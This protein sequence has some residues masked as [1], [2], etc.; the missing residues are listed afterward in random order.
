[1]L[2][3]YADTG[4]LLAPPNKNVIIVKEGSDAVL[5]CTPYKTDTTVVLYKDIFG[6]ARVSTN[7]C[8]LTIKD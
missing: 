6:F 7:Y 2:V 4:H 1:L 8:L 5:P 3:V